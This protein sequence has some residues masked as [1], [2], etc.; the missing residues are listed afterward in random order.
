MALSN[1]V[2]FILG[3]T[4][5]DNEYESASYTIAKYLAQ[6]N[7]VYYI[8]NP[9]TWK[10]YFK[11]KNTVQLEKR[12]KHFSPGSDGLIDTEI[13]N[14]K[15]VITP[16]LLSINFLPEG[17]IYRQL[18]KYNE[19]KISKR[20]NKIVQ[21]K[22]IITSYY[23]NSF[24]FHYPNIAQ[25]F[26]PLLTVYHC[27]DP[28]ILPFDRRHGVISENHLLKNSDVIVCTSK[29][30]YEEKKEVN[31]NTY[32]IPNAADISHCSK[33]LDED[34]LIHKS[35]NDFKKPIIGYFGNIERRIDYKLI[36]DVAAKNPDKSFVFAGPIGHAF[37]PEWFFKTK[38]IYTTGRLDYDQLPA[39]LKGFDIALIPFKK[40]EVSATIFPLKLFEYL[41]AGKPVIATNFNPDL[42]EFTKGTVRYCSTSDEFSEAINEEL[43]LNS[44]IRINRRIDIANEN[45]WTKRV[46]EFSDLLALNSS[47]KSL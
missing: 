33:A 13:P 39:V 19:S 5:F 27:V 31:S 9:Y 1:Q 37:V 16:L 22:K 35:L 14:L 36:A 26:K 4:K 2:I 34:L 29:Q 40:D 38:N 47:L 44:E 11:L 24:N 32:F 43:L 18:L 28:L 45:T 7:Q 17:F 41:G 12:K 42:E 25:H 3:T 30:L 6:N 23:I 46:I 20:I 15:I 10:D 21:N 8:E